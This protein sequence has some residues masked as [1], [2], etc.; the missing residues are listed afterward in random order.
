[1]SAILKRRTVDQMISITLLSG[2]ALFS[3]GLIILIF[4]LMKS[5]DL[6][7]EAF[8]IFL[9]LY[10]L[11]SALIGAKLLSKTLEV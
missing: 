3:L 9:G 7:L 8:L 1:M 11:I 2:F 5:S 4:K 10:L 6:P